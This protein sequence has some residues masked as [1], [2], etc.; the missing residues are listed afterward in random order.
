MYP[1]IK[2]IDTNKHDLIDNFQMIDIEASGF[3]NYQQFNQSFLKL[4]LQ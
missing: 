2:F 1:I 4:G 3:I